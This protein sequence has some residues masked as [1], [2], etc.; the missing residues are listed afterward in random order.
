MG[1]VERGVRMLKGSLRNIKKAG[2]QF[3]KALDIIAR[4]NEENI[5][6]KTE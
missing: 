2:E 5:T 3:G 1:L 6:Y 4:G